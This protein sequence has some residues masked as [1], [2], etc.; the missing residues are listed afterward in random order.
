MLP[1]VCASGLILSRYGRPVLGLLPMTRTLHGIVTAAVRGA[2]RSERRTSAAEEVG[3]LGERLELGQIVVLAILARL[4]ERVR[5]L[6]HAERRPDIVHERRRGRVGC[7]GR[8]VLGCQSRAHRSGSRTGRSCCASWRQV[9]L[10]GSQQVWTDRDRR[11][12]RCMQ[13]AT[14]TAASSR[15]AV[16]SA[17]ASP[18]TDRRRRQSS[19]Q[20]QVRCEPRIRSGEA[21]ATRRR[22]ATAVDRESKYSSE[23]E[24]L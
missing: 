24:M 7:A 15:L 17:Q 14:S 23:D 4:L 22:G 19:G 21:L 13:V 12:A 10:A 8:R 2:R 6:V 1:I 5:V 20:E 18:T 16:A 9:T 11:L 3:L